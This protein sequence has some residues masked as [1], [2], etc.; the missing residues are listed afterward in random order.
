MN[1]ILDILVVVYTNSIVYVVLQ[2]GTP[3]LSF[4]T[5]ILSLFYI[6]RKLKKEFY[7]KDK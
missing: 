5:T 6:I 1:K 7:T 4:V 3:I 2:Y